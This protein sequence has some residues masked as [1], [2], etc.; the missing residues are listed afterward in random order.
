[1]NPAKVGTRMPLEYQIRDW[2]EN[3]LDFLEPGLELLKKEQY[4]PNSKGTAGFVDLFATDSD[5]RAVVIE[6]K[7]SESAARE[8]ITELAKY[9]ALLRDSRKLRKSEMR[10][11]LVSTNWKEL[12]APFSEWVDSTDYQVLGYEVTANL[13]GSL[14]EKK[15]REPLPLSD[16]RKICRRQF[17]LFYK[18]DHA[19]DQAETA[20]DAM[21]RSCSIQDYLIFRVRVSEENVYDVTR[22]LIFAQQLQDKKF[23]LSRLKER[24]GEEE[25]KEVVDYTADHGDP[26]DTLDELA[27]HL[28][29]FD[30]IP[31]E[32][33]QICDPEKVSRMM[34][35]GNW[36]ALS[37]KRSGAF[38]RDER[39]KDDQ[40]W[41]ELSGLGGTSF[42]RYAVFARTDDRAKL[43]E[44]NR[45]LETTLFNNAE[46][47]HTIADL[48]RY[49]SGFREASL[50][51]LVHDPS[52]IVD[53]LYSVI[54]LGNESAVPF[55]WLSLD[56]EQGSQVF[57]GTVR[58][59]GSPVP[60]LHQLIRQTFGGDFFDGFLMARHFGEQKA[61]NSSLMS[62][63]GLTFGTDC[64][65]VVPS[66]K[67]LY[68]IDVR[69]TQITG[70]SVPSGFAIIEFVNQNP[71]FVR[72]LI[73]GYD[74][75]A[76]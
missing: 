22:G 30:E 36:E 20:I 24:L 53:S 58:W 74:T 28:P 62:A 7:R 68:D 75:Y 39:L 48:L 47:R 60:D 52:S 67:S 44:I 51:L 66:E 72:D 8:A 70:R 5:N 59:N 23:Y 56:I 2:L 27:D 32:T 17:I 14:S 73:D 42:S 76:G 4:F 34:S 38:A 35:T 43:V 19:C 46:W 64:H 55:F 54:K 63:L 13:D 65:H 69:G 16:G 49:A 15:L 11:I 21:T 10:F 50:A 41:F 25:F 31:R 40:L 9:A 29:D 26:D 6:I 18:D 57:V 12:Y 33:A 71:S 1:M 61:S 37:I 45:A 3:H